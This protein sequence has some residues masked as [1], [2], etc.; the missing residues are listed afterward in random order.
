MAVHLSQEQLGAMIGARRVAVTRAFSEL[1]R[2][3]V[4]ELR[5]RCIYVKDVKALER[6]AGS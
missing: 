1:R 3:G 5:C 6:A 2:S 4:E